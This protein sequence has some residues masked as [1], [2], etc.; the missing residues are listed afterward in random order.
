MAYDDEF[1]EGIFAPFFNKLVQSL[2]YID[3]LIA[4]LFGSARLAVL[5][6]S[7]YGTNW[8]WSAL[9]GH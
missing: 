1:I 5:G 6:V 2:L 9:S 7:K 3:N 8:G 4:W